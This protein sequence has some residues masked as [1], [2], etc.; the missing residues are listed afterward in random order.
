MQYASVG[1]FFLLL[2]NIPLYGYSTFAYLSSDWHLSGSN[3]LSILNNA[4]M[5]THR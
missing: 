2:N 4:E 5:Y 1:H 3:F